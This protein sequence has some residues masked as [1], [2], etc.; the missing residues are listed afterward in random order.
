MRTAQQLVQSRLEL[1][2][3]SAEINDL[4]TR[5]ALSQVEIEQ[6][7]AEIINLQSQL[8]QSQAK[9]DRKSA[10]VTSLQARLALANKESPYVQV[11]NVLN[12]IISHVVSSSC[13]KFNVPK[14]RGG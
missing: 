4:Q 10:E 9:V 13:D 7:S 6:K 8:S 11:T 5:L 14:D 2:Q 1:A 3:K 12:V